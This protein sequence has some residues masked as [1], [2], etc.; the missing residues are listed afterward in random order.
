MLEGP[1]PVVVCD[2]VGGVVADLTRRRRWWLIVRGLF[3]AAATAAILVA[4]YY[5][6]PLDRRSDVY[7]LLELAIGFG[8]LVGM[9]A[10]QVR[11]IVR[12]DYPAIRAAEALAATTPLFLL[13]FAAT[14]FVLGLDDPAMFTERL[15]RSD[16]LYFSIT[17]FSTVGFGDIS[18]Q[19][20]TARL[21][22]AAQMLLDLVVLGLG[23]RLILGA[24]QRGRAQ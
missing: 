2:A 3:R 19:A 12:S 14:Y 1:G 9:I 17:I 6:L 15:S 5:V 11:A 13:L 20:E 7:V 24:V 8:V 21:V 23:I 16:A 22:V 18:P 10:W 4:L